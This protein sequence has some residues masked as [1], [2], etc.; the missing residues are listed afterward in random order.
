MVL[1]TQSDFSK[2][3]NNNNLDTLTQANTRPHSG[4]REDSNGFSRLIDESCPFVKFKCQMKPKPKLKMQLFCFCDFD[5]T[6]TSAFANSEDARPS[7]RGETANR[8]CHYLGFSGFQTNRLKRVCLV[9]APTV[10]EVS[11]R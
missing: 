5:L 4:P 8:S 7:S 11:C 10:V 3:N 2:K 1:V 9:Y 6:T